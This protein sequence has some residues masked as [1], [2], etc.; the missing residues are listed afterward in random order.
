MKNKILI[1]KNLNIDEY[2]KV[3]NT[4]SFNHQQG[5]FYL[6]YNYLPEDFKIKI[7]NSNIT[8]IERYVGD[9]RK[10]SC[11]YDVDEASIITRFAIVVNSDDVYDIKKTINNNGEYH[12]MQIDLSNGDSNNVE[13]I[14]LN[15]S[16]AVATF[17]AGL[18]GVNKAGKTY[19]TTINHNEMNT[20][21]KIKIFAVN[22]DEANIKIYTDAFIKKGA[23]QSIAL[24]EG[25]II[26]LTEN[27]K[28]LVYPDLHIDDN[29]V[30][31]AHSCSVGNVNPEHLYYLE[32]RGF[33]K[34]EAEKILIKGYFNP[35]FEGVKEQD[36]K[37]EIN[38]V[39][40]ERLK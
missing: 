3:S 12:L 19:V 8:L 31:A 5:T 10:A 4:L 33:S 27:C 20:N 36:I 14:N 40:D 37:D 1:D 13:T 34:E 6:T 2:D 38:K 32:S 25:R 23:H 28:G 24:Q 7:I 11:S 26:N 29:D 16:N 15:N 35:L 17:T 9:F 18:Y 22:D 21:S 30:Q 39:L